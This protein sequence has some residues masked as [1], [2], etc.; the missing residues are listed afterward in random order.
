MSYYIMTQKLVRIIG[1]L[2][3]F[4][5][6]YSKKYILNF[7]SFS[8]DFIEPFGKPTIIILRRELFLSLCVFDGRFRLIR[9]SWSLLLA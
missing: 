3:Y 5:A 8:S 2:S 1:E 7:D 6:F 9:S 4:E